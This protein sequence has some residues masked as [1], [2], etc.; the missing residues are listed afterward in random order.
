[1]PWESIG[2]CGAADA[3]RQQERMVAEVKLGVAYVRLICGEPPAR[4]K[5][6]VMWRESDSVSYASVGLYYDTEGAPWDCIGVAERVLSRFDE[7]VDWEPIV[8]DE[9]EDDDEDVEDEDEDED[10]DVDDEEDEDQG[11]AAIVRD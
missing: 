9:D 11:E 5:L 2:V 8:P 7:V 10:E 1:M 3:I 4:C 6:G